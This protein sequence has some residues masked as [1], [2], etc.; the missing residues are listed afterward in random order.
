MR[1]KRIDEIEQYIIQ[2]NRYLSTRLCDVFQVSKIRYA[3]I[4]IHLQRQE[5]SKKF[6]EASLSLKH[7][8]PKA[9]SICRTPRKIYGKKKRRYAALPQINVKTGISF[10]LIP[11]QPAITW[12]IIFLKSAVRSQQ[13]AFGIL[14]GP[15]GP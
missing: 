15:A 5:K 10:I 6:M 1:T 7:F 9:A 2:K 13:T 14:K 11:E 8:L 4:S 12:W 3:E